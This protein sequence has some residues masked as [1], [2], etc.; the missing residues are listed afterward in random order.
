MS[1]AR[2]PRPKPPWLRA[3]RGGGLGQDLQADVA[4]RGAERAAQP[5]LPAPFEDR[6]HHDVRDS[7]RADQKRH[8]AES[9]QERRELSAGG[10]SGLER[11]G[12]DTDAD[13]VGCL[14]VGRR[15]Q[16][17]GGLRDRVDVGLDVDLG[18]V[19][20]DAEQPLGHG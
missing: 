12:R 5:D 11:V 14:W 15:G 9:E 20:G 10:G 2:M 16:Q 13:S 8:R 4:P 19:R 17:R 1:V 3:P 18:R 6:Q 7:D